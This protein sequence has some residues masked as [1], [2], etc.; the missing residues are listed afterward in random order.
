[1]LRLYFFGANIETDAIANDKTNFGDNVGVLRLPIGY[2]L[3][4]GPRRLER[5]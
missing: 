5:K 2:Y 1:M 3:L 4:R